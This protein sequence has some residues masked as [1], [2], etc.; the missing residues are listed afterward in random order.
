MHTQSKG[1]L[2]DRSL[3]NDT[4]QYTAIFLGIYERWTGLRVVM[5]SQGLSRKK[6]WGLHN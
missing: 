4:V 3:S 1:A 6:K 5:L 2:P